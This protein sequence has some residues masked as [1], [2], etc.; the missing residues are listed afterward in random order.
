MWHTLLLWLIGAPFVAPLKTDVTL[1]FQLKDGFMWVA[2]SVAEGP[3]TLNLLLDTGAEVTTLDLNT[4]K[5]LNLKR[6]RPVK[7][8][9]VGGKGTGY[10]PQTLNATLAGAKL[11][12]RVLVT[13]LCALQASCQCPIDGLLGA[14]FF[15]HR[16]VHIDFKAKTIS[17]LA[18]APAHNGPILPIRFRRSIM[19]VPVTVD[20]RRSQ[21]LRLDTGCASPLEWVSS[22][23][24]RS[25]RGSKIS[26]GLA[27]FRLPTAYTNVELG[28]HHFEHVPAGIHSAPLFPGEAGLLGLGLLSRFEHV[29]I[30]GRA[31]QLLLSGRPE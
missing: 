17:L 29:T 10:W 15:R 22:N 30:D 1:P 28:K 9:G 7:V 27:A 4:A 25:T 8:A 24:P 12:S 21:W 16:V 11:P 20:G 19:Q 2:V 23:A 13:D 3:E 18:E 14:D 31:G 6:G 26:V 5:R